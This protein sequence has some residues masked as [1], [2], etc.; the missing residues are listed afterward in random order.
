MQERRAYR[1][2]KSKR[3]YVPLTEAEYGDLVWWSHHLK[4]PVADMMRQQ[5][6]DLVK[7]A[8]AAR[9]ELDP[10]YVPF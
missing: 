1:I 3:V 8:R 5:C 4:R 7:K 6:Y 10:D 9:L 2:P